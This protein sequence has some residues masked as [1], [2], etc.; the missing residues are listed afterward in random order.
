MHPN[1]THLPLPLYLPSTFAPPNREN[2]LFV[3][4]VLCPTVYP[5]PHTS[6]LVNVHCNDLFVWYKASG[7]CY[8]VNTG[9]PM[10]FFM[11]LLP[12]V[13]EIL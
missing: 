6:L 5:F 4:A 12:C 8:S 1:S 11:D 7:F 3:E 13:I 10:G 9:T 2:N